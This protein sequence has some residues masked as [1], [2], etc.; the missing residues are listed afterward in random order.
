MCGVLRE[1]VEA[2]F[3]GRQ[4]VCFMEEMERPAN[5]GS[6]LSEGLSDSH[7]LLMAT[8][9]MAGADFGALC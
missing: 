7:A 8:P 9:A 2:V 4:S 1:P 5:P 6:H 3:C